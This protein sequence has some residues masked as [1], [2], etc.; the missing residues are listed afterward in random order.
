VLP[1]RHS[2]FVSQIIG[3]SGSHAQEF[4]PRR[5]NAHETT[6]KNLQDR[7]PTFVGRKIFGAYKTVHLI[8]VLFLAFFAIL[9]LQPHCAAQS[10]NSESVIKFEKKTTATGAT[11][12]AKHPGETALIGTS[13]P[14]AT[15]STFKRLTNELE[16]AI[17]E[18]RKEPTSSNFTDVNSVLEQFK[19]LLDLRRISRATRSLVS[20]DT[21]SYLLDILG[22]I[23]TPDAE[24]I[25][26][27]QAMST[28]DNPKYWQLPNTDITI[29]RIADG[30]LEG[31]YLFSARTVA[32]APYS[33]ERIKHLPLNSL[34][35]IDNWR[36][37]ILDLHGPMIPAKLVTS[38]P[39]KLK[40]DWNYTPIWKILFA[41]L[42]LVIA[43][44]ICAILLPPIKPAKDNFST[45]S[46]LRRVLMSLIVVSAAWFS[47][48]FLA[49]QIYLQGIVR[50]PFD[51]IISLV[52]CGAL[53]WLFWII[54][55]GICE[56][57]I[58][59][60]KI[61]DESL[62]AEL[63]RLASRVLG[64]CGSLLIMLYGA[65]SVGI[66]AFGVLAGLGIGGLAVALAIRPTLEN[67]IGG[68]ILYIDRP[69]RVGDLC[70][71]DDNMGR[72]EKIGPRTTQIRALD[73]TVISVP[74][75]S[76]ADMNLTN[77]EACDRR[78]INTTLGL[79]YETKPD[80]LRYI[81]EKLR[82]MCVAHS[83][84]D[85]ETIRIRF[86]DFAASSINISVRIF[87]LTTDRNEFFAIREDILFRIAEIVE[88]SGSD[89]AFPSSTLY[90]GRDSQ[91][92]EHKTEQAL[93]TVQE[94]RDS[95]KPPFPDTY[96]MDNKD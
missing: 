87:A 51:F 52:I 79:R 84:I 38:L 70:S 49:D 78:L 21:T 19:Y 73:R 53:A 13:D 8:T 24:S 91:L 57:I 46:V 34:M 69:V 68:V 30:F 80:Q 12:T 40:Q 93:K 64:F 67:L 26:D 50:W 62:D 18:Y 2:G 17:L 66:P 63:L 65:H 48:K 61:P 82:A 58:R 32:Q 72:V 86:T 45:I 89:F 55:M 20:R 96:S 42:L 43:T 31:E 4:A 83:K 9:P 11:S 56:W 3:S 44:I 77:W 33:Y 35:P 74:N 95:G 22:R 39:P 27:R 94:W 16:I 25:P 14:R 6:S 7:A 76:F 15:F 90:F 71:F 36:R 41:A 1:S 60:P 81:L 10:L 29:A 47:Q 54:V 37:E 75:A 59:S 28:G 88:S 5:S 85:T 92:D 23:P